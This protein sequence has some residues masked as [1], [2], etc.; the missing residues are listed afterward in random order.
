MMY[1]LKRKFLRIY[2]KHRYTLHHLGGGGG[3]GG[4]GVNPYRKLRGLQALLC[5]NDVWIHSNNVVYSAS[6]SFVMFIFLLNL[7]NT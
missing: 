3:G 7:L 4:G 6:F 2:L 1:H 5:A